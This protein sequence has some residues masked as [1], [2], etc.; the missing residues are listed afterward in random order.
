MDRR[1]ERKWG[2]RGGNCL[3]C[4][5]SVGPRAT[6]NSLL[7]IFRTLKKLAFTSSFEAFKGL[8]KASRD[9]IEVSVENSSPPTGLWLTWDRLTDDWKSGIWQSR[10]SPWFLTGA[11]PNS[12]VCLTYLPTTKYH[13]SWS[14]VHWDRKFIN[15]TTELNST[16]SNSGVEFG[17][18]MS[19]LNSRIPHPNSKI[20]HLNST[21]S[22]LAPLSNL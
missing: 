9:P 15:S 17:I 4:L 18:W 22:N 11:E 7:L 14:I 13:I 10:T 8:F 21:V 2:E 6:T 12:Q 5:G 1:R 20:R 16:L 19:N 3:K